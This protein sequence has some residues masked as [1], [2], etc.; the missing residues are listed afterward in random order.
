MKKIISIILSSVLALSI[1]VSASAA[2]GYVHNGMNANIEYDAIVKDG[3][4][5]VPVSKVAFY[6]MVRSSED[7]SKGTVTI[8]ALGRSGYFTLT[9]GSNIAKKN[10]VN[11]VISGTPF[12]SS[13]VMYGPADFIGEQL[14]L[15]IV[16]DSA[17]NIVTISNTGDGKIST[18]TEQQTAAA[19][20]EKMVTKSELEAAGKGPDSVN[21]R[22]QQDYLANKPI[23][24]SALIYKQKAAA[25]STS[26]SGEKMVTKSQ[27]E[28]AGKG[29]DSVNWRYQ[30]DYLANKP[31]PESALIYK[32]KT[33]KKSSSSSSS[34][35]GYTPSDKG[36][37]G[38]IFSPI[39]DTFDAIFGKGSSDYY[40]EH[41]H[42]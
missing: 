13:G 25:P 12:M 34:S 17:S 2:T 6:G 11:I 36:L 38:D 27:L 26:S 1:C 33:Q 7:A 3:K 39:T 29:P 8:E 37:I 31:I 28:A 41:G 15:S 23:P 35:S 9:A 40:L 18:V 21:W 4:L 22:Y 19:P 30:Q 42:L 24:E 10:G 32:P 16:Y 5:Y 20:G 14:G